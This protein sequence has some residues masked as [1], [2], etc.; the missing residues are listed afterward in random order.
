VRTN[1]TFYDH[2]R[3]PAR[4]LVGGEHRGWSLITSQLNFERVSL[5]PSGPTERLVEEAIAWARETRLA[6]GRR[7]IDQEWVQIQLAKVKARSDVLRLMNWKMAQRAQAGLLHPAESSAVK[8]FG[9]ESGIEIYQML[10]ELF[11]AAGALRDGSPGAVL[12]G[13]VERMYRTALIM[14]FGGG[15][16]EV[17]R[18]IIAMAGLGLPHY[19]G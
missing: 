19:K 4:Y 8:V 14:T 9:S 13:R 15:T 12:R 17:Q 2:V 10:L 18:D 1:A 16:N 6:D 11:G 7:V 5:A 3:V